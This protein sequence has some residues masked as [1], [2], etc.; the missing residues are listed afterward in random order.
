MATDTSALRDGPQQTQVAEDDYQS[1]SAALGASERG[2]AFLHEYARRNRHADTEIVLEALVR[3]EQVA[4]SQ[5][6]EPEADRI[7]QDLRALLDTIR[8]A[9]PQIDSTPGAIKA[10]TLSALF[11]FVQA[12]IEALVQPMTGMQAYLVPEPEQRELPIPRPGTSAQRTI[13]LVQAIAAPP[14]PLSSPPDPQ[15]EP[16]AFALTLDPRVPATSRNFDPDVAWPEPPRST[17]IIPEVNFIDSLFDEIDAKTK[18]QKKAEAAAA[19][20]V[21]NDPAAA[22]PLT[23]PTPAAA[24]TPT[25]VAAILASVDMPGPVATPVDTQ[26]AD[27]A[28]SPVDETMTIGETVALTDDDTVGMAESITRASATAAAINASAAA[29]DEIVAAAAVA[30]AEEAAR[31]EAAPI[32][33]AFVETFV[34]A[35]NAVSEPAAAAQAETIVPAAA[36]EP[37]TSYL[38]DAISKAATPSQPA[39]N[40][41]LTAIMA[42]SD[43]ERLA[44]FT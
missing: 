12:R 19:S 22:V 23:A 18:A 16:H 34:V 32:E 33:T 15:A 2:R 11:E 30:L 24:A 29:I 44:L 3:L 25:A 13:A 10:A 1:F 28:A 37:A 35:S 31:A 36:P 41:A 42:L 21:A 38:T 9:R 43:E 40:D 6:S 27:A 7:R 17:K 5:K 8:S 4:Q 14:D 39:M 20:A 26:T